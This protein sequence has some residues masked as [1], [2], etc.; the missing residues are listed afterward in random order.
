MLRTRTLAALL[1]LLTLSA[2]AQTADPAQTPVARVFH[3]TAPLP[4]YD[5]ATI[6]PDEPAGTTAP[7]GMRFFR[8]LT[9]R[10]YIRNAYGPGTPLA[11]AQLIGGPDWIDKDKYDINGKP[12][13]DLEVAMKKMTNEDRS[14]QTRSM[15]QSLLA[16]RF[17]L[18]VHFEVREMPVYVLAPAKGGLKIKAVEAPPARDPG[19][20]LQPPPPPAPGQKPPM[21]AGMMF[22][23]MKSN[24]ERTMRAHATQMP[25]L[26]NLIGQQG[27]VGDR[28]IIDQTGFTGY[29]D[30][31]LT[32]APL[33]AAASSPDSNGALSSDAPSL[34]TALEE[35][36]GLKLVSTK[37]PVE[38]IVIDSI[39]HPSEN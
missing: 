34:T 4:S 22:V 7:N 10:Q 28:P 35:T 5:V 12:S 37:G 11:T 29:F 8:G 39:D 24:G 27:G 32:F 16:E 19:T 21:P 30:F 31:D 26:L 20:P 14:A 36:L 17:H 38:V 3:P 1:T 2:S 9:I 18:K 23:M 13:P 33:T 25:N 15:Q 6:K